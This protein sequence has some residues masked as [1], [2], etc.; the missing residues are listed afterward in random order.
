VRLA[1][2]P[3]RGA[4]RR[5]RPGAGAAAA[6]LIAAAVLF[7]GAG[8]A[9]TAAGDRIFPATL[10]LPQV[11]PT[12]E[13]YLNVATQPFAAATPG[14][15]RRE[16]DFTGVF[17]KTLTER[18]GV[19]F[20]GAFT[21]L[22]RH[23]AGPAEGWQ[24]LEI[25]VKYLAVLDP[26]H[27]FLLSLGVNREFGGTGS[28]AVGASPSGATTPTVYMAKGLGD[29]DIGYLRPL[30]IGA[31]IGHPIADRSP[32]PDLLAAGVVVEYSL[33]YL[34]SKVA[35]V[36]LPD[37]LRGVTAMTELF[38]TTPT[39]PSHGATTAAVV[40]P[41]LSY[42][43]AGWEFGIEAMLP[44]TRARGTGLGVTAQFHLALDYLLPDVA[45]PLFAP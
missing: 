37:W 41:G 13:F 26:P 5:R 23:M 6:L 8:Q 36:P 20:E 10:I 29:L 35:A 32:R 33:P 18:L 11:A 9:Y 3:P 40:A 19:Q 34:E 31:T 7:P 27:E 39:G 24:N 1:A 25:A 44:A 2:S 45:R 12:D 17:T 42:A 28:A 14:A 30:A 22:D 38:L 21:R 4:D 16:T 15:R 43:G